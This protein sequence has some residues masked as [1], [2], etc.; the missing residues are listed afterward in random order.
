LARKWKKKFDEADKKQILKG[1]I[2]AAVVVV[3]AVLGVVI[4]RNFI[5]EGKPFDVHNNQ[6]F[7]PKQG[8]LLEVDSTSEAEM[9][10]AVCL[11]PV[12]TADQGGAFL[13][14]LFFK[15]DS[16][17]PL[18][19][20]STHSYTTQPVYS[21][22]TDRGRISVAIA[23]EYWRSVG[24]AVVVSNYTMAL[25]ASPLAS[26][27]NA[28]II[29]DSK[30][31]AKYLESWDVESVI[32]VGDCREYENIPTKHLPDYIA[33]WEFLIERG[34]S[35]D[36]IVVVNP[37]DIETD[38][39]NY[40]IHSLSMTAAALAAEHRA[41]VIAENF[42]VPYNYTTDLGYGLDEAGS[43]ERG[44]GTPFTESEKELRQLRIADQVIRIDNRIDEANE[45]IRDNT[46]SPAKYVA[47][48]GD[49]TSVPMMYLKSPIWF[50]GVNQD[51]KGE[52]FTATDIYY[53]DT[54]IVLG[55][56]SNHDINNNWNH[57]SD[58]L[59]TQEIAVGRIVGADVLDASA[60]VARS[61]AYWD[62]CYVPNLL[63]LDTWQR[64]AWILNSLMTGTSDTGAGRHQQE[65]FLENGMLTEYW[66]PRRMA[67]AEGVNFPEQGNRTKA[68]YD[69]QDTNAVIYDGHG[70]PDGWYHMWTT[71]G[72][73]DADWDRIGYE[74]VRTLNMHATPVF[75]A[76]CLTSA[77][78]WP[79]VGKSTEDDTSYTVMTPDKCF[80]LAV[81]RGGASCYIGATEESWGMFFGALFDT[82]P[83]VWGFGDFDMPT[84]FWE[85]LFRGKDC[86]TALKD[87][88][89]TFF[90]E[91]WPTY[92][93]RPF[94]RQCILE[95][96]LYGDPAAP[97]GFPDL[98]P[99][100]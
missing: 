32:T 23:E 78:D 95:T 25:V 42:S 13:K 7:P 74:D 63:N 90:E 80:S 89:Y 44:G 79:Y 45:F 39:P 38:D 81:I 8:V 41:L 24:T 57:I 36:Y 26:L 53:G 29:Y 64:R 82:D 19:V 100:A 83:D 88:K 34:V 15:M 4:Y 1:L 28:P 99:T 52:E 60:L 50:E 14:P 93:G 61:L 97:Y 37:Y 9:Q 87:A 66:T 43:G 10:A 92:E 86:G 3:A 51:A 59:Y 33:V 18:S 84:M 55:E 85:E 47:L 56:G 73:P 12:T 30:A 65:V 70:Y 54:D 98:G 76:C 77:L 68:V 31:A 17:V 94:A 6:A 49:Q 22:G 48:V 27:I 96:V 21:W 69:L 71:T 35:P 58:L 91:I 16:D 72:D 11:A 62:D 2:I 5:Y 46:G 75:G 40:Y 67:S 20:S